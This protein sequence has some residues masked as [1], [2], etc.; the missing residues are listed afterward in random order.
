[1]D[2]GDKYSEQLD[3]THSCSTCT[4]ATFDRKGNDGGIIAANREKE[5]V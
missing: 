5:Q 1:M 2:Q 4:T 3:I